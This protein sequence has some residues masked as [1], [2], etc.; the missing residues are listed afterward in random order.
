MDLR[1][2]E[3]KELIAHAKQIAENQDCDA[4]TCAYQ[5]DRLVDWLE[6][7]QKYRTTGLA[8]EQVKDMAENAETCLLT[9]FE[10]RYGFPVG[11]LM[12]LLEA[13]QEN[14]LAVLPFRF[15]TWVQRK[16]DGRL[17]SVEEIA[18]NSDGF[19]LYVSGGDN[20]FYAKPDDVIPTNSVKRG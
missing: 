2:M 9:W 13:K 20:G 8:A 12:G 19:I 17:G 15:G 14:R 10:A 6:E 3:L 11:T 5:H 7:L 18:Y 4:H 16:S 1:D